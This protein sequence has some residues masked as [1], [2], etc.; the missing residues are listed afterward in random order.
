MNVLD[1]LKRK[2]HNTET[3]MFSGSLSRAI[4]GMAPGEILQ[5]TAT[6]GLVIAILSMEDL[7]YILEKADMCTRSAQD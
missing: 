6:D 5:A 4:R 2:R 1:L 3:M 7:Q